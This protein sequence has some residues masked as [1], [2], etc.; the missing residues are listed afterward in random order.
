MRNLLVS[1]SGGETSAYLAKWLLD[2]KSNDYNMK[3]V[4]ANTGDE[5]EATLDFV[6]ECSIKWN[7]DIV[8]VESLVYKNKRKASGQRS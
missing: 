8:W 3:F 7:I 5:E 1:F 4:F 2:N 6:Q